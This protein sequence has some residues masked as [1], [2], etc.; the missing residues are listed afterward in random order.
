M[1][2]E[3]LSDP[4]GIAVDGDDNAYVSDGHGG[5]IY[6]VAKDGAV[7]L[8]TDRLDMPS[9]LAVVQSFWRANFLIVANTGAHTVSYVPLSNAY[10]VATTVYVQPGFGTEPLAVASHRY[11]LVIR[12]SEVHAGAL[13]DTVVLKASLNTGAGLELWI[14][15]IPVNPKSFNSPAETAQAVLQGLAAQMAKDNLLAAARN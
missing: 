3:T 7:T 12:E 4:F 6:R 1:N 14:A 10:R 5:R 2:A 15:D 9:A 11:T 13:G 8:V